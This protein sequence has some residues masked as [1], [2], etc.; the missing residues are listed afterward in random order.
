M[1]HELPP[2]WT[3]TSLDRV[4]KWSSGGTPSR[5]HPEYYGGTIPWIKT[6]E[7]GPTYITDTEEKITQLGLENSSAKLFPKGSVALA[8]Y[9]ATIGKTSILGIDAATNQACAVGVPIDGITTSQFLYLYLRSQKQPFIEAGK[10]GAQPNISQGTVKNWLIPVPPFNEQLRMAEKLEGLLNRVDNC[11][12]RLTQVPELLRAFKTSVLIAATQGR[13]THEWRSTHEENDSGSTLVN[14]IIEERL[15]SESGTEKRKF[16][17]FLSKFKIN[18]ES[19]ISLPNSWVHTYIGC[20]GRVSNGSTPSRTKTE[21]WNGD[22]PWV[23]SGEV[24]NKAITMTREHITQLGY[25]NTSVRLLPPGT[26]LLAMIGEGKTRGQSAVLN[27]SACINQNIAAIV[28]DERFVE[29]KYLWY[30]LQGAYEKNRQAGSGTGPQAL[31]CQRVRELPLYLPPIAEQR[32]IIRQIERLFMFLERLEDT[33]DSAFTFVEQITPSLLAKAFRGELIPQD[34][35]EE[36]AAESIARLQKPAPP[37]TNKKNV[38][39]LVNTQQSDIEVAIEKS[40][41]QSMN[42]GSKKAKA[43]VRKDLLSVLQEANRPMTPEELFQ[44]SGNT[45][46]SVDEFYAE[47]KKLTCSEARIVENRTDGLVLLRAKE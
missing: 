32:E 3:V 8:M 13:L 18:Q 27:I 10:G 17:E 19:D 9:G 6:G 35:N 38:T 37:E 5:S 23:S 33:L 46:D 44:A 21:Y 22:I 12:E 26:V 47:L 42:K 16:E 15:R 2:G 40:K 24:R 30:W 14:S 41:E 4:A 28:L 7:L 31:N 45:Q 25:K 43:G 1:S 29:P 11:V 36:S 20:V 34:P 39:L